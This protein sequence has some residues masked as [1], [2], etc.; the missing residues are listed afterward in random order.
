LTTTPSRVRE[1]G[2]R[3]CK[4]TNFTRDLK[5]K[6]KHQIGRRANDLPITQ[7][8]G[9]Q[10]R[11]HK[12]RIDIC[13][14]TR[15][16]RSKGSSVHRRRGKSISR[17]LRSTRISN[18]PRWSRKPIVDSHLGI[19]RGQSQIRCSH[20]I[21]VHKTLIVQIKLNLEQGRLVNLTKLRM[22][23]ERR[24]QRRGWRGR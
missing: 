22:R 13:L 6:P 18:I 16:G 21:R 3:I 19:R 24:Q 1:L 17:N 5:R 4:D 8:L 2:R 7:A 14:Q 9:I 12:T 11:D 20:Q 15:G 10:V 23:T